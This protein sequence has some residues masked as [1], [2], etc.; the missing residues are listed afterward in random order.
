MNTIN[1]DSARKYIKEFELQALFVEVLG[2]LYPND[3]RQHTFTAKDV[4]YRASQIATLGGAAAYHIV[5]PDGG[6]PDIKKRQ[7]IA[8]DITKRTHENICIF[9]DSKKTTAVWMWTKHHNKKRYFRSLNYYQ[10]QS[11]KALLLR[12]SELYTDLLE[13]ENNDDITVLKATKKLRG[14]FD[15]ERT[16]KKFYDKFKGIH[17]KLTDAV[18]GIDD[19]EHRRWYASV[20][21]NRLMFIYFLQKN[22]VI[23]NDTQFLLNKYF[24]VAFR[25]ENYFTEFFLPL[26]FYGFAKRDTDPQKQA[27]TRK[28]GSVR[29]LNGGLFYPHELE[30]KYETKIISIKEKNGTMTY[31]LS[32]LITV[33]NDTIKEVLEFLDRYDW[34]LDNRPINNENEINPDVLGYIFEKYINQKEL[35]AYYTKEDITE[36]IAKNTIL[37]F[38]LDRLRERFD[39]KLTHYVFPDPNELI[40]QNADIIQ[41]GKDAVDQINDYATL[42]F[43]YRDVLTPLSI[44]DPSVGSGAFLFAAMK[45]LKPLYEI[46]VHKLLEYYHKWFKQDFLVEVRHDPEYLNRKRGNDNDF[47]FLPPEESNIELWNER[48]PDPWLAEFYS[49]FQHHGT[50]YHI[51]KL[52]LLNNLHGVDIEEEAVEICKLRLFLQLASELPDVKAIEP[53]PDIDFNIYAGNSLV[54][55]LSWEDLQKNYAMNLF[56]DEAA[57]KANIEALAAVKR[58]YRA[59]QQRT[60]HEHTLKELKDQIL[61]LEKSVNT[62]IDIRIKNAF[63]WFIEFADVLKRGGFDV[64]IGNPP[65]VEYSQIQSQYRITGYSTES[66]GNLYVY[67]TERSFSITHINSYVSFIV[68][69][70]LVCTD[71]MI[72]IQKFMI[73]NLKPIWLANFDDRPG[74][75]FDGLEHI[76]AVIFLG[77]KEIV[78]SIK[79]N[80]EIYTTKYNRWYSEER[81]NL[82]ASLSYTKIDVTLYEGTIVKVGSEIELNILRKIIQ[83]KPIG[84]NAVDAFGSNVFFHNAPQY[85]IRATDFLPYFWNERDGQKQSTGIKTIQ[86]S[87]K[88]F[89]IVLSI[90]NSSLFYWWFIIT[91]D[92]RHLNL[93]EIE[94]FPLVLTIGDNDIAVIEKLNQRLFTNYEATKRRKEAKYKRTGK[95][96]YDEYFPKFSKSIIDEIDKVLAC[97]YGLTEKETE[98]IINYDLRFRM[99]SGVE[100]E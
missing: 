13:F 20:I 58:E 78:S 90:I 12:L 38:I 7:N 64:I 17:Q 82:F 56:A 3:D 61:Y 4:S 32:S 57:L 89:Q 94:N 15:I 87:K 50:D 97:H 28:F 49:G 48:K 65:Y 80:P 29:Y 93:R 83:H 70:S 25:N 16:T 22:F 46:V 18:Q 30:S 14:A 34:Y 33:D 75:L 31:Q 95:V 86:I 77:K 53:L 63:H 51:T 99:G 62:N 35:G 45:I 43:L 98:F 96:I 39:R 59:E 66:C 47:S 2:W 26:C 52:I 76:R 37:P 73:N 85:W 71:R 79:E 24:E 36:Y 54:G 9:T 8:D 84:S 55:G 44:L 72:P 74:K 5:M 27:F 23:Q 60:T 69:N 6:I 81:N 88:Y 10:E 40:T 19:E 91:S 100:E 42:K 11:G 41:A 92:G 68:Q 1:L 67:L 21:L